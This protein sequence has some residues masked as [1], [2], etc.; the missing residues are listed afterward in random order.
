MEQRA[1]IKFCL[2][3]GKKF[4]ETYELLKKVYGDD[5]M[6]RTQVYTRFTR[7][8]NVHD[9]LNDDP[10]PGRPEASNRAEFVEK[11]REIIA[12]D[13]NFTVRMLAEESNLSY[14]TIY[15]ILT[16]DLDKRR[17]YARFAP[18][19]LN[20]PPHKIKKVNEFLMKKR[21]VSSTTLRIRLIYHHVTIFC[22][23]N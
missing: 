23:Q 5:C 3:L 16:E 20:A 2:K 1:N 17:V 12:I 14:Y 15:T 6:S 8:M 13:A 4:S 10:R 18:H 11:V 19:Q 21:F 7:F 22:S 9:D